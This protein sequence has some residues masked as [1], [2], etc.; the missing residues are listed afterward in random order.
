MI[1]VGAPNEKMRVLLSETECP[2]GRGKRGARINFGIIGPH[3]QLSG[4][5]YSVR[6]FKCGRQ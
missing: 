4:N 2:R 6:P 3:H 5:F 1:E